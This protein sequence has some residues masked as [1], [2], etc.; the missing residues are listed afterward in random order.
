MPQPLYVDRRFA[1]PAELCA[2]LQEHYWRR[3][4]VVF[5]NHGLGEVLGGAA[6]ILAG[7]RAARRL[8]HPPRVYADGRWLPGA[9]SHWCTEEDGSIEAYL[10][11]L[12][13]EPGASETLIVGDAF[14]RNSARIWLRAAQFLPALYEA[15]GFP[16]GDAQIHLFAG[17]Y[18]RTPFGFHKDIADSLSYAVAGHKRYLVWDYDVVA[19]HLPMPVGARHENL[20]FERYDYRR[21]MSCA[22]VMD[23]R[24]GDIFYWPWDCFHIAEPN[25]G[26]F[27]VTITFGVSPFAAPG[28]S[29]AGVVARRAPYATRS[30]P[31]QAGPQ[32]DLAAGHVG[33]LE[34]ALADE[35]VLAGLR[36]ALLHRRTR[37]GFKQPLPLCAAEPLADDD[38]VAPRLPRPIAWMRH[39]GGLLVSVN[40]HGFTTDEHPG[41]VELLLEVNRGAPLRVGDLRAR[42]IL[43]DDELDQVLQ[44][45]V[46]FGALEREAV[47]AGV[48]ATRTVKL[49]ADLFDRSGLFPL[50]LSDDGESVLLAPITDDQHRRIEGF[51]TTATRVP[52]AQ[53]LDLYTREPPRA[54]RSRW[55]FTQGYS[56]STLLCRGIDAMPGCFAVHEPPVL[57]DWALRYATLEGVDR[58]RAWI[59]VLE[60]LTALLFRSRDGEASVV[61][62]VG[63]HV[64]DVMEE[65]FGL[66]RQATGVHLYTSLPA[67]LA[68]TL[69]DG[70]RRAALREVVRAPG[71]AAMLRRIGAPVVDVERLDDAQAIT[72]LWL[73]DLESSR[74]VRAMAGGRLHA[75]EFDGFL[76]APG[77]GLR[78]LADHLGLG[79]PAGREV[80]LAGSDLFRRHAKPGRPATFDRASRAA[81][82]ETQLLRHDDEIQAALRWARGLWG[83]ALPERITEDLLA[84]RVA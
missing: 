64:P 46:R 25:N 79:L 73:T 44:C 38:R 60:L 72:Y 70:G 82:V 77:C 11:R 62:K 84:R 74:S 51:D 4:P 78:A 67:F 34:R 80:E 66:D 71:R 55:I 20:R 59:R 5:R 12:A 8:K 45:L 63:P 50:R 18:T 32:P 40:G 81:A 61:V 69:K 76:E 49:P 7:L 10:D 15:V 24:P 56:G 36:E 6:D 16:V 22:V 37:L 21:L 83:A 54:R 53:L 35:A 42:G 29:E 27:S 48:R 23:T 47:G 2:V 13:R 33:A 14:E 3:A 58:R 52:I 43:E 75:L 65:I 19:R 26:E 68:N 30:E 31:F 39:A 41:L 17:K 57:D 28:L 9:E 1:S